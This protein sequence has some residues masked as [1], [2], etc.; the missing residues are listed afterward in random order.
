M[1]Q[2]ALGKDKLHY[3]KA[4]KE[5]VENSFAAVDNQLVP[6]HLERTAEWLLKLQPQADEALLTAGVSHDIERAFRED[7][8]YKKMFLS[9]NAFKD[10]VFL[11]YHQQRSAKIITGFL[12]SLNCPAALS[13]KVYH[14]VAHHEIGGDAESDLLKDADS[15][16]FFATNVDLFINVKVGE[17]SIDKVRNKFDWM[18]ERITCHKARAICKPLYNDALTRLNR[19]EK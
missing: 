4:A 2:P 10:P 16:S 9:R 13:E 12:N 7:S 17:S 19:L 6:L 15:L 5:F 1:S 14:L 3:Y 11:D 8:V 18:F